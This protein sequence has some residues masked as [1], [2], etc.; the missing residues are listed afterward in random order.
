MHSLQKQ[1]HDFIH[2][3]HL[4]ERD[5]KVLLAVSGGLDSMVMAHLFVKEG[6]NVS[7]AH[8][9]F[10]LRG[11]ES[12]GDEAFVMQWADQHGLNCYVKSFDLGA[13]SIQIE[14]RNARYQWFNELALEN[15]FGKIAVAHH[16]NDSLETVL[17]NLTRGTGIKGVAGISIQNKKIIRPLLFAEKPM[18]YAYAMDTGLE[19]REDSSNQRTEYDRNLIR[20]E[21]IP[22]LE[23]I[24]PSL[25]KTFVN[26]SERL[27]LAQQLVEQRVEEVKTKDLSE[28]PNGWELDLGWM[29]HPSDELVLSEILAEFEVNYATAKEIAQARGKS[30]KTF[31]VGG[32]V[33]S[34]DRT[35]LFVGKPEKQ[36]F[37]PLIIKE[38]GVYSV[39]DHQL[40][41]E[42]VDRDEVVFGV[43]HKAYLDAGKLTFPITI[44]NWEVGDKIQPLGMQ[45]KKKVSDLLVD[46][47][48]PLHRKGSVLVLE[49]NGE[50]AWVIGYRVS[51]LFKIADGTKEVTKMVFN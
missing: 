25:L 15:D 47:K 10:G 27:F 8:C 18:L 46:Q 34:M 2:S 3:N 40:T 30:G 23:K 21:V 19:W 41:L 37:Q 22:I 45:G 31:P 5:E 42:R 32:L 35:S 24:N 39:G 4:V 9:N 17:I 51:D 28:R 38:E 48:V 36:K 44:R 29:R 16:L 50:I 14:A 12:D 7:I 1:F 20:H 33:I 6:M 13:G 11:E 49:S 43:K 26:T